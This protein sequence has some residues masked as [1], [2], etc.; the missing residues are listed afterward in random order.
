MA[1]TALVIGLF[2]NRLRRRRAEA[3]LAALNASL[4][5]RVMERTRE[6]HEAN[7]ELHDA[8]EELESL[9]ASLERISRT[10]SLTGLPNRRRAE[11]ALHDAL[12]RFQRYGQDFVVA[13]ADIDH[14]KRVNDACGHEAGDGVLREIA[15]ILAGG[16]RECDLAARWGG[17]EFLLLLPQTDIAGASALL[18]RIRQA[19]AA[20]GLGC[21]TPPTSVTA[22]IGAAEIR[23]GERLDDVIRRADEALYAGKA[24]GRNRLVLEPTG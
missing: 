11:E 1:E 20:A 21:G 18:E 22:T 14:F 15:R 9:N 19:I 7:E 13:V 3:A 2:V 12:A 17:E 5:A 24:Q 4:E 6:L 10:D 23:P 8:K 16:V